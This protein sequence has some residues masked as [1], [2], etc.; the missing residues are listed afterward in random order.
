MSVPG[1]ATT[2][3]HPGFRGWS[4]KYKS[5]PFPGEKGTEVTA[6]GGDGVGGSNPNT[7]A[8]LLKVM[9]AG[10]MANPGALV[11]YQQQNKPNKCKRLFKHFF[12]LCKEQLFLGSGHGARCEPSRKWGGPPIPRLSWWIGCPGPATALPSEVTLLVTVTHLAAT[13]SHL[14]ERT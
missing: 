3:V 7:S 2:W 4:T 13:K 10:P 9:A 6:P 8:L 14:P 1:D 5:C 12:S 11:I